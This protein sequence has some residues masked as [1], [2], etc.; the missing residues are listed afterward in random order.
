MIIRNS[1]GKIDVIEISKFNNDK[2]FNSYIY[3]LNYEKYKN[4]ETFKIEKC[5]N[6]NYS[7]FLVNNFLS[8]ELNKSF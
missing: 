3:S 1:F 8:N 6:N 4:F 5:K 2:Q 7:L